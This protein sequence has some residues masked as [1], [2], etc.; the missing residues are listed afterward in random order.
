MWTSYQLDPDLF[1]NKLWCP[2][3]YFLMITNLIQRF[4]HKWYPTDYERCLSLYYLKLFKIHQVFPVWKPSQFDSVIY[5][6]ISCALS[7][8]V[9][10]S[11]EVSDYCIYCNNQIYKEILSALALIVSSD[12]WGNHDI[13]CYYIYCLL[14]LYVTSKVICSSTWHD[15][16][17]LCYGDEEVRI[18]TMEGVVQRF[19]YKM[20]TFSSLAIKPSHC[21]LV[22]LF[23]I[24]YIMKQG[25]LLWGWASE[26]PLE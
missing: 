13:S 4:L 20:V 11:E 22:I 23:N 17:M 1:L 5:W 24:L 25:M 21:R 15:L 8:A 3:Y 26:Y 7:P 9:G 18:E 19:F 10:K 2:I 14:L 16:H 12:R 6:V